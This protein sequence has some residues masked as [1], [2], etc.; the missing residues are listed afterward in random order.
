MW[1]VV[2]AVLL[3]VAVVAEGQ[4]INT[5]VLTANG[6]MNG[7]TDG[8]GHKV[9]TTSILF[10]SYTCIYIIFKYHT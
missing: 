3:L 9:T 5:T 7:T 6:W 1:T 10:Y 4:S 2:A 8:K